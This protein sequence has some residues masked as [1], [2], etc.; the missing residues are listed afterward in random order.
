WGLIH[1]VLLL[2]QFGVGC[3]GLEALNAPCGPTSRSS[4]D[5]YHTSVGTFQKGLPFGNPRLAQGQLSNFRLNLV[6]TERGCHVN[7]TF[8]TQESGDS[9]TPAIFRL[10][11]AC[12]IKT[13]CHGARSRSSG[14]VCLLDYRAGSLLVTLLYPGSIR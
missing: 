7:G 1:V 5:M 10:L 9:A 12:C 6:H 2:S 4:G 3:A 14:T 8:H 11:V 13:P